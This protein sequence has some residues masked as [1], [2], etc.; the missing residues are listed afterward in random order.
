MPTEPL[1]PPEDRSDDDRSADPTVGIPRP[2]SLDRGPKE[3]RGPDVSSAPDPGG[4][5]WQRFGG[6]NMPVA[7]AS[8]LL[9][10]AVLIGTVV[11]SPMAFTGLV[12]ALVL[13]AIVETCRSLRREGVESAT[14][15][16]LIAGLIMLVGTFRAGFAGLGVGVAVL[17][18]GAF[19]WEMADNDRRD[20]VSTV[21]TTVLLGLWIPFLASYAILL[22]TLPEDAWVALIAA[23][24]VPVISDIGAFI[25]GTRYGQRRLAPSISP[26]KSWEGV[27]GGLGIA[28][29]VAVIVFPFLGG[30]GIFNPATAVIFALTVGTAGIVGDLT[31]SMVKRDVGIK[32]IG[33]ILPGHGGVLDRVDSILF[34]LPTA[35]YV[36]ALLG[37]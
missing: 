2:D 13:V 11:W 24:A 28:T 25:V 6:R 33:G 31:E 8:G 15:V 20:I 9:L 29:V 26:K 32:D 12:V 35:Y 14:P 7:I 27:A 17:L 16:I 23:V 37:R 18:V 36:L 3:A 21:S 1:P 10:A 5:G 30:A 22:I 19:V 4:D 34:A